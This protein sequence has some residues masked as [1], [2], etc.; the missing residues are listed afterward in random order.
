[1]VNEVRLSAE[2]LASIQ[3]PADVACQPAPDSPLVGTWKGHW[4]VRGLKDADMVLTI[5]G[6]TPDGVP[7]GTVKIGDGP[8]LPPVTDTNAV[9]PP[10]L[11]AGGGVSFTLGSPMRE[12][13]PGYPYQMLKVQ[14]TAT[15]LAFQLSYNEILRPWCQPQPAYVY[16]FS[17]LP[18]ST[19]ASSNGCFAGSISIECF[20]M[21][22]CSSSTCFCYD[23]RCDATVAGV[24]FDLHWDGPAL[25]GSLNNTQLLFLDRVAP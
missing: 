13:W 16:S 22:Y 9:Y 18:G 20:K 7:C 3:W 10:M 6:L 11:G 8:A 24:A 23:G 17:C 12:P 2:D 1:V 5:S 21:D 4:P 25:E 15:R 19:G 14:S